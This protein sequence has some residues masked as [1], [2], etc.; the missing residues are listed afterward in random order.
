M[1]HKFTPGRTTLEEIGTNPT[2]LA[3]DKG[4]GE[5]VTFGTGSSLT[6]GKLYYLSTNGAWTETDA[7]TIG[8]SDG[9]LAIALGAA[10][11]DGMHLRG[12]FDAHS[13]LANFISGL[14]VYLSTTS[15]GMDTTKPSGTDKVVRCVGYCTNTA[16]VIYFNPESSHLELS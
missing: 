1:A 4:A 3:D 2:S 11:S 12:F 13:H 7:D 5:V 9:M 14:P 10:P 8:N 16:N 6:A 15:G